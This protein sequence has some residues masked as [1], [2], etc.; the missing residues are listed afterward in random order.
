MHGQNH[1]KFLL[2]HALTYFPHQFAFQSSS[3][4]YVCRHHTLCCSSGT[5]VFYFHQCIL[6]REER[7]Q[8]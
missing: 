4:Q 1:I 7:W 6:T 8:H 2:L 3:A 5:S